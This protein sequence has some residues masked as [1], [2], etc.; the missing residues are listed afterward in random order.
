MKEDDVIQVVR[1]HNTGL[2]GVVMSLQ[3]PTRATVWGRAPEDMRGFTVS[4]LEEEVMIIGRGKVRPTKR[5][6]EAVVPVPS[7]LSQQTELARQFTDNLR[8]EMS[9]A[10]VQPQPV[11]DIGQAGAPPVAPEAGQA[12]GSL[13]EPIIDPLEP[14]VFKRQSAADMPKP[15]PHET[16]ALPNPAASPGRK[17]RRP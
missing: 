10:A 12:G 1:G 15:T 2:L 17:G 9:A 14:V 11:S 7:V 8:Q 6:D 16:Q 13:P 3:S 5:P 4:V